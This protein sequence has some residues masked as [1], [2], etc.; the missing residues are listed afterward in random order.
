ARNLN[1]DYVLNVGDNFYWGGVETS[2]G[3]NPDVEGFAFEQWGPI[4]EHMYKGPGLD[5][6][7][8]LGVLGNHDYGGYSFTAA[9]DESIRYTWGAGAI[10]SSGRW[11]T[12]A[13]YWQVLV[14]YR[15][16]SVDYYF[17][18]TNVYDTWQITQQMN[19]NICGELHNKP[20]A[21][22]TETGGPRSLSAC[23]S[24]FTDLWDL[25]VTWIEQQLNKSTADWQVVVTHF[26]PE[27]DPKFWSSLSQRHGIDLIIAGHRHYQMVRAAEDDSNEITG[28]AVII[29]GG[30]GGITSERKPDLMGDDDAYGFVDLH[31]SK[32]MIKVTAITHGGSVRKVVEV[33]PRQPAPRRSKEKSQYEERSQ[34]V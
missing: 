10:D 19:H 11:M 28:T 4:Y 30:G 1:P 25:Q 6:K 14:H 15:G 9:W 34:Y 27:Y 32:T 5:K 23:N 20:H 33:I 22:C 8:W 18:D 3:R 29:S 2:C 31:L 7:P 24:W 12:P 21:N 26:P 16:F 13:Q 17:M